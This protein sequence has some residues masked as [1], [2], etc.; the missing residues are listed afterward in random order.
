MCE[1]YAYAGKTKRLICTI[2]PEEGAREAIS[3]R[4]SSRRQEIRSKRVANAQALV[5]KFDHLFEAESSLLTSH[6][7]LTHCV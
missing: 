1:L 7:Q 5:E 6:G 2:Q 3:V 4:V